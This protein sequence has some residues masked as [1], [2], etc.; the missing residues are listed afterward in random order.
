MFYKMI[1]KVYR[2]SVYSRADDNGCVFYFSKDD[3]EGLHQKSYPFKSS[4]GHQLQGYFY[5][6]DGYR[7]GRIVIFEHGMGSGHRGYMKEIELLAKHGYLVF[8]YDHTGCMES[9]GETTF[10]FTQSL[11]DLNDAVS[12]LKKDV[13]YQGMTL[14][15]VGH[16]W[17][18][19][20]TLNITA[21]HPDIKHVVAMAGFVSVERI[22]KQS[23]GGILS[24]FGKRIY[25]KE[26]QENTQYIGY[27]AV[28]TL[29]NTKAKV[30]VLHSEDDNVVKCSEHFEVMQ[31]ALADKSNIQFVKLQG[32][33]HNPN[34]TAEAV[35]YK[36]AFFATYQKALKKKQ[37]KT[38]ADKKAFKAGFD[39]HKMTEQDMRVWE[40]IFEVLD[41]E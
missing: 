25:E 30:L 35:K 32:K 26:A 8:A 12:A 19:F 27:N 38:E 13:Q 3:F 24:G 18:G 16:S 6:Y 2:Q 7:E 37:F 17:G 9:G 40:M 4:R 28:E 15:V 20:S 39:W 33:L 10:G 22:L 34:Y 31:E 14:S 23:F 36:D 29:K 11:M 5:Y 1:E 41:K 21:F